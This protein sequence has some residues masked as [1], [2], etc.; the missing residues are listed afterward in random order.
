[1]LIRL[2]VCTLLA[3]AA[4]SGLA[5]ADDAQDQATAAE[6]ETVGEPTMIPE[7]LIPTVPDDSSGD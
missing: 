1:M 2:T 5:R 4:V 3:A 6:Q 7:S